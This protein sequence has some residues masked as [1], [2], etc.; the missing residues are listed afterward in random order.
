MHLPEAGKHKCP[1]LELV[2]CSRE[3]KAT[4]IAFGNALQE[5]SKQELKKIGNTKA[6]D[7]RKEFL[8]NLDKHAKDTQQIT[9]DLITELDNQEGGLNKTFE[10]G[11][12]FLLKWYRDNF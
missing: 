9:V 8:R 6:Y 12:S 10:G 5:I 4:D 3:S 7:M 11:C 2:A 1:G